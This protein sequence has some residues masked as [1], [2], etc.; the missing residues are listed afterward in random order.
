M[1]GLRAYKA[2]HLAAAMVA[3]VTSIVYLP[4]LRNGFLNWDDPEY[5]TS[6]P[7]IRSLWSIIDSGHH[8]FMQL[9]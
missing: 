4:C 2:K 6:N 8:R 7:V 1:R 9:S 3:L 5:I